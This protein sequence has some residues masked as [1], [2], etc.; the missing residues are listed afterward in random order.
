MSTDRK[1]VEK[2]IANA[3]SGKGAHVAAKNAFEGLDWKQAGAQPE[4]TGHSVFQLL[5]HMNFWNQWVVKWLAGQKPPIPKHAP[6]GWPGNVA[7]QNAEEWRR[8]MRSFDQAVRAMLQAVQ[9]ADPL[10]KRGT[11]TALEMLQALAS[12]NSYHL[13]QVVAARQRLG[14][15]PP[16]SGGLTW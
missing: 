3:L 9:R 7:P 1:V 14:A 2:V 15:W 6:G 4:G 16:P 5:N 10:A 12:H 11:K 13:G 8:A